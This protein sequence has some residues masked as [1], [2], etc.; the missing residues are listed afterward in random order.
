VSAVLT[1]DRY[2]A[3]ANNTGS[4]GR[5][6]GMNALDRYAGLGTSGIGLTDPASQ[7]LVA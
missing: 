1:Q 7:D 3:I 5:D 4:G 6:K 2:G